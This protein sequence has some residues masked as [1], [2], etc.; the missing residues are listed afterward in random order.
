[1]WKLQVWCLT[2]NNYAMILIFSLHFFCWRMM[3]LTFMKVVF[4]T[5]PWQSPWW[6]TSLV[7]IRNPAWWPH[8]TVSPVSSL[9]HFCSSWA[10]LPSFSSAHRS[11]GRGLSD[12][13]VL[14]VEWWLQCWL[15]LEWTHSQFRGDSERTKQMQEWW[16]MCSYKKV[17][18]SIFPP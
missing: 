18:A 15:S 7:H 11:S 2:Y 9:P 14:R 17:V 4:R 6:P 12:S 3:G 8:R 10:Q 16:T 1:M 5:H 13:G